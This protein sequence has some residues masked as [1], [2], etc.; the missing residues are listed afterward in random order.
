LTDYECTAASA[1][2]EPADK[3]GAGSGK[4]AGS[5]G[6]TNQDETP[7]KSRNNR[8]EGLSPDG[9]WFAFIKDENVRVR[10]EK[11]GKEVA[12][13]QDG[14]AGNTYG[15]L[16]WAPDSQAL[17]AW[18]IEPGDRKDVYLIQSS[19]PGGG[20][21]LLK[22]RPYALPGD[23]FALYEPSVFDMAIL[24]HIKP[25]VDRFEHEW[26]TPR[27]HWMRDNRHF[28]YEQVD[29]GHQ[30][31][32][33][34]EVDS[35]TGTTRNLVDEKTKTFI[36][37]AH[38]EEL[39]INYVNWLEKTDE[40]IYV[41]EMDGWR[42]LY[43]VDIKEGRIKNQ[44]T[45][46]EYVVRG[47][48][49]I[50]EENR[51]VWFRASG[52]NPEQ[53]PY[54]IHYYRAN[55]DGSGLIA[56][57]EGNGNHSL[58]FSPDRKYYIDTYSRVDMAPVHELWRTADCTRI[59]QFEQADVSELKGSGWEPPEVFSAKGRDGKT[60]IWGIICRPHPFDLAKKYPVLE[61]I[62]AGPQGS[63]VPKSFSGFRRF[64]SLTDLG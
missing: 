49:R 43:L 30:R 18:R 22:S 8:R 31:L 51:Q 37:T 12:L 28:A 47:I 62:Y 40:M 26:E 48:D 57:T 60:D 52:G 16:E 4:S 35:R 17:V 39:N 23:K 38:T 24:K 19:P 33:V 45:R 3:E 11:D 32:R 9:K 6:Q 59:C 21:A 20:R 7:R 42:H 44:I 58:Q 25:Q 13:T 34:I 2:S 53:D 10:S 14:E 64:A 46:G 56:L 5:A 15:R 36:W 54:F 55:F 29:R 41:S 1:N 61:Q 50:D 63:Y 27:L